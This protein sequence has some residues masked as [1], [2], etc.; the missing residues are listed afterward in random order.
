MNRKVWGSGVD[1]V[2]EVESKE[3]L[4]TDIGAALDLFMSVSYESGCHRIIL[5][6]ELFCEEFFELRTK[7]AGEILQKCMNYH[8]KLAVY[9]DFSGHSGKAL[10]DFIYESNQGHDFFFVGSVDE[11]VERLRNAL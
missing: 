3:I 10:K 7:M 8:I 1:P 6:K 5:A 2:V 11:A 9:G 4:I